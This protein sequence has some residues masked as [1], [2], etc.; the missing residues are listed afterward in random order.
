[1]LGI[2]SFVSAQAIMQWQNPMGGSQDEEIY[3]IDACPD[4]G[5][6]AAGYTYSSNGDVSQSLGDRDIWVVKTNGTGQLQWE[7]SLGGS[8]SDVAHSVISVSD[9]GYLVAGFVKSQDG[10]VTGH[11]GSYDGWLIK[12]SASGNIEWQ[13]A[14]GSDGW[15]EL[16]MVIQTTDGGFI[17]VGDGDNNNGDVSGNHGFDDVWVVKLSASGN[18]QW[19]K[20][21]GGTHSDRG[22]AIQQTTDGGYIVGGITKSSNGDVT[23]NVGDNYYD[24]W[25]VKLDASGQMQWQKTYGGSKDDLLKSIK[26]TEDGGYVLSGRSESING[27]V[28]NNHGMSDY[29]VV[30]INASGQMEWQKSLGGSNIEWFG[31]LEPTPGGGYLMAGLTGSSNG[32][33]SDLNG[34]RDFWVVAINGQ[35]NLLWNKNFG[36]T[37]CDDAYDLLLRPDGSFVVA[38]GTCSWNGDVSGHHGGSDFW[39]LQAKASTVGLNQP[40]EVAALNLFPNP[41]ADLVYLQTGENVFELQVTVFNALGQVVHKET[42]GKD[43]GLDLSGMANGMYL[44]QAVDPSGRQYLGKLQVVHP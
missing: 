29:W 2:Q 28:T 38:G 27:D 19:Q 39:M 10:Q 5:Y 43:E 40:A 24:Y 30:K 3:A 11:H 15:E 12:L 34:V 18:I 14:I 13:K 4:G 33:V 41:A 23:G 42:M 20:C 35:G 9:G 37:D 22:R 1:M 25:A 7:K 6:I 21:L 31:D 16:R 8:D 17:A 32:D 44:V 36:G 26:C